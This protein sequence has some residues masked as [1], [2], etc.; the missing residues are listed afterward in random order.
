MS[1][2]LRLFDYLN[3]SGNFGYPT[4][5]NEKHTSSIYWNINS[6][7]IQT[8]KL[9]NIF[10]MS[11]NVN[12]FDALQDFYTKGGLIDCKIA[13][14]LVQHIISYNKNRINYSSFYLPYPKLP[15]CTKIDDKSIP[16]IEGEFGYLTTIKKYS[17]TYHSGL[18]V[19]CVGKKKRKN[20]YLSFSPFF[21]QPRTLKEICNY[22]NRDNSE[23]W[24]EKFLEEQTKYSVYMFHVYC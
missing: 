4:T 15:N 1:E 11:K 17:K 18:N 20:I 9:A 12:I 8:S 7:T 21:T 13:I 24:F 5:D 19:I 22:M 10:V 23:D 16:T 2:V 6:S 3:K 14:S